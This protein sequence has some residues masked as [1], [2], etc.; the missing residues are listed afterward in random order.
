MEDKKKSVHCIRINNETKKQRSKQLKRTRFRMKQTTCSHHC[1]P[2]LSV[3]SNPIY[4][5]LPLKTLLILTSLHHKH[6]PLTTF[7]YQKTVLKNLLNASRTLHWRMLASSNL[8]RLIKPK[9]SK[10]NVYKHLNQIANFCNSVKN[11]IKPFL[12]FFFLFFSIFY[13]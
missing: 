11:W 2:P 7:N 9:T 13:S 4:C 8:K 1:Y 3:V 5:H 6:L 10:S 12:I